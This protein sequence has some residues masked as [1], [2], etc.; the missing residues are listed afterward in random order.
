MKIFSYR[1]LLMVIGAVVLAAAVYTASGRLAGSS[2]LERARSLYESGDEKG[3]YRLFED[4][5]NKRP[6]SRLGKE[7]LYYLCRMGRGTTD[8]RMA[9]WHK[10]LDGEPTG[11]ARA[12][13]MLELAVLYREKG[14][15]EKAIETYNG[16]IRSASGD[17]REVRAMRELA[18]LYRSTGKLK[19]ARDML[20]SI[21]EEHPGTPEV[22]EIQ[23]N[24]GE[25]NVEAILSRKI[26]EPLSLE[27]VVKPGDSLAKITKKF[28][29]TVDLLK[30][31]N[32]KKDGTIRVNDR[33]K[34]VTADFAILIDK[35]QCTLSLL[36]N[37][38][39]F[40]IYS[41]GTGR[42]N[43]TPVGAFKVTDKIVEPV[44]YKPGG[45]EI[46]YGDPGNLLGTRWINIDLPGYGIHGTWEPETIGKQMSAGCIR[47]LNE[48][49]EEL[50][51]I[52]PLGTPVTIVD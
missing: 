10:F 21:L 36:A 20:E 37:G 6:D 3:A 15:N 11:D 38:D 17:G 51:M 49:V 45:G 5:Y 31:C 8:E 9:L 52:I 22:G 27:Y 24:M 44:W 12:A 35:S 13:G 26:D 34:V 1:M 4:I 32:N 2:R 41:V 42:D 39:L 25:I 28:N 33:L 16:V 46:P 14:E 40:K 18:S 48:D 19:E 43:I 7:A 29:T 50:F 30:A 47:L 23:N